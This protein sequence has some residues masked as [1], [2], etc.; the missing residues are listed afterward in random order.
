ML[1]RVIH[2]TYE[3]EDGFLKLKERLEDINNQDCDKECAFYGSGSMTC[4]LTTCAVMEGT[5]PKNVPTKH[6]KCIWRPLF[7]KQ[8]NLVWKN[9]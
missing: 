4:T 1:M 3:D 8:H 9:E 6:D 2:E 5:F 7:L